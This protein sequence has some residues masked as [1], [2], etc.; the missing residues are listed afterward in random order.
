M[1]KKTISAWKTAV[2]F[3]KDEAQRKRAIETLRRNRLSGLWSRLTHRALLEANVEDFVLRLHRSKQSRWI[4]A[5]FYEWRAFVSSSSRAR[6]LN[7][8]L[9]DRSNRRTLAVGFRQWQKREKL[10]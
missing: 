1:Q 5:C 10:L 3:G 8:C 4:F 9:S 6:K 2:E 7:L